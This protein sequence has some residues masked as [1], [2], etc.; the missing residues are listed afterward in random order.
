MVDGWAEI[1]VPAHHHPLRSAQAAL[2]QSPA[3]CAPSNPPHKQ[4]NYF[5]QSPG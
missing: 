1:P 3:L 4:D 5:V 2:Q